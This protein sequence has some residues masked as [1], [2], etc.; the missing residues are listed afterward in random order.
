MEIIAHRG[1]RHSNVGHEKNHAEH[2]ENTVPAILSA[3]HHQFPV[4]CDLRTTKDGVGVISHDDEISRR[5]DEAQ[6]RVRLSEYTIHDLREMGLVGL[7]DKTPTLENLLESIEHRSERLYLE[8]KTEASAR[9]AVDLL[10]L[11]FKSDAKLPFRLTISSFVV[12]ALKLVHEELPGIDI[13]WGVKH[14][15]LANKSSE[16]RIRFI[17]TLIEKWKVPEVHVD[18]R[19]GETHGVVSWYQEMGCAVKVWTINTVED[20]RK[21]QDTG[22][23]AIFSDF[24]EMMREVQS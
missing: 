2:W 9:A 7:G 12:K 4:E 1:F 23:N 20:F 24:P 17:S 11:R 8:L 3:M 10:K 18:I 13:A 22:V 21:V 16:E 6:Q 14:D 5:M 19:L 15:T